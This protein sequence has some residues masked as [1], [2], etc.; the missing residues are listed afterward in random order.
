MVSLKCHLDTSLS[1]HFA[2][3]LSATTSGFVLNPGNAGDCFLPS[4][5]SL[6]R[7]TTGGAYFPEVDGL[8]FVAIFIVLLY[9][10]LRLSRMHMGYYPL[11]TN[12]FARFAY[13]EVLNGPSGVPLFFAISGFILGLPFAKQYL[14]GGKK[15][16][17]GS[18]LMRRVTRLEPPYIASLLIRVGPVMAAKGISFTAILPHLLASIF[19]LHVL[20]YRELPVLQ[21]VAWSLEIEVQFYFLIFFIAPL[22]FQPNR[23]RRRTV[24]VV[25]MFLPGILQIPLFTIF[26]GPLYI[27]YVT[28]VF[29]IQFFL[30][31]L[32]IADLF[33]TDFD[34]IPI[35]W[36]WDILSTVLWVVFFWL[37][38]SAFQIFAP[39]ILVLLFLGAFKGR[40][41]PRIFAFAPISIIG[42]MCYSIYLTHSLVLQ[43]IGWA[44][45]K[46]ASHGSVYARFLLSEIVFVPIL[47]AAGAVFFVLIERPCMD[48]MWPQKLMA[49]LRGKKD[50]SDALPAKADV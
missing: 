44:Y 19:Y 30:A 15:I 12:V 26:P 1:C 3:A 28:I 22:L 6:R 23:M 47:I 5:P 37:Q 25:L 10:V 17:F 20:I 49:F 13:S 41:F 2:L 11:P 34:R 38:R 48:K 18:Y 35:S 39:S 36:L 50:H 9:H 16:G 45:Y 24:F 40:I 7:I 14:K 33:V 21:L 27:I 32:F 42:G 8:R 4:F 29:S 43:G 46:F 31:G